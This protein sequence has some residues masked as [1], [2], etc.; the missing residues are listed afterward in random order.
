MR[1]IEKL[2]EA[3][4]RGALDEVSS[5]LS[6]HPEL[7][8]EKDDAGA[9]PLHYAAFGGHR[10]VVECL[11]AH[12]ANINAP[13]SKFGATPAG[14]AIEYL[15]EKGG[16]LGIELSDFAFAIETGDLEWARRFL[17][18]FPRLRHAVDL[19]GRPFADLASRTG[20]HEII[21]LFHS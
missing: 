3:A 13:D 19:Q 2:I 6:V 5:L 17:K 10:P 12:G 20:N 18:R 9:T 14:W 1:E 8:N 4:K 15:R 7:V 21:Q 11:I 16:F